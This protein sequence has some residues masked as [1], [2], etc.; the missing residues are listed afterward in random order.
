MIYPDQNLPWPVEYSVVRG[1][2]EEEQGPGGGCA[3]VSYLCPAKVWT[4]GWGETDNVGPG[5]RCTKEQADRWLCDDLTD[6]V[7]VIL[8]ACKVKPNA[9]QLGAFLRFAYNIGLGWDPNKPKPKGAKDGF[10][11]STVLKR[12]NEGNFEAAARAFDLWNEAFNPTTGKREVSRGLTARRKREAAEYLKPIAEVI[13]PTPQ[14]VSPESSLT[15]S[16]IVKTSTVGVGAGVIGLFSQAG[17]HIEAVKPVVKGAR[18]L[19]VDTLGVPVE[20]LLPAAVIGVGL[21]IIR[22]RLQQRKEGWA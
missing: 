14:E 10:R 15:E 3:L 20:W 7:A 12:H 9:N 19:M 18:E 22:W 5:D 1:I 21:L 16:K 8:A 2:S 17:E 11:Q 13:M 6:R 4:I